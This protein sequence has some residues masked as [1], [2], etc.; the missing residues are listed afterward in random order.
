MPVK[1]FPAIGVVLSVALGTAGLWADNPRAGES[2][3]GF[4][5]ITG[6]ETR[7]RLLDRAVKLERAIDNAPLCD[8]LE[9][10]SDKYEVRIKLDDRA[11][12][13]AGVPNVGKSL[14]K[15]K[16][17]TARGQDILDQLTDQIDGF[18]IVRGDTILIR[19]STKK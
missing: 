10:L 2:R 12:S 15:L 11:F 3:P 4:P 9:F 6:S 13:R 16:A 18:F 14:C 7:R 8:I 17:Q 5:A 1:R 19:P